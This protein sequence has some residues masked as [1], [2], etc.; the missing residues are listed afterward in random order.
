MKRGLQ[1][2]RGTL[3][4][5]LH[6]SRCGGMGNILRGR[7]S[8]LM[9]FQGEELKDGCI[10]YVGWFAHDSACSKLLPLQIKVRFDCYLI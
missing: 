10:V 3:A 9:K 8:S 2:D 1:E 7:K 5:T 4:L 6:N